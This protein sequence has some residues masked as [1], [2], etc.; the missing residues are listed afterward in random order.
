M[1]GK[2]HTCFV[3]ES[4]DQEAQLASV[5][6]EELMEKASWRR[7][8]LSKSLRDDQDDSGENGRQNN[9]VVS[10]TKAKLMWERV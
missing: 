6:R 1:E 2:R 8:L 3:G 9:P 10:A 7:Y 4:K 5:W